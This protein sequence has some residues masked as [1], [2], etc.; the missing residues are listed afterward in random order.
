MRQPV[1]VRAIGDVLAVSPTALAATAM[2][3]HHRQD[4]IVQKGA[5][6]MHSLNWSPPRG[7]RSAR[8]AV[9]SAL[10]ACGMLLA[11]VQPAA[12]QLVDRTHQHIVVTVPDDEV[13][14]VPVT[15]TAD[16]INNDQIRLANS[17][18]PLFMRT[19][20]VTVTWTNPVTGKSVSNFF[21]GGLSKDL[22][23][24][25]NGDGTITVRTAITG[26][27]EKI[28]QANGK[29]MIMDVGRLVIVSVINY[30]GTPTDTSDDVTISTDV[31]SISGPHPDLQSDF[32]LFCQVVV[33]ALT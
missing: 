5:I 28:T 12:A 16:I 27:P 33:P 13:C 8:L 26:V 3:C 15:T 9:L 6:A 19:G 31:E 23:V 18:F 10:A 17:G 21:A 25:D 29:P 4:Q 22:T 30:N 1:L 32:T 2:A 7:S 11:M 14:G 24:V 20:R